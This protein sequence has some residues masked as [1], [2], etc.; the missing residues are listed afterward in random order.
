LIALGGL[1]LAMGC[2]STPGMPV[3]TT[4][5][6][7][8][9]GVPCPAP[10]PTGPDLSINPSLK[11]P[12]LVAGP[13][14]PIILPPGAQLPKQ[15]ELVAPTLPTLPSPRMPDASAIVPPKDITP[16]LT[17]NP[18]PDVGTLPAPAIKPLLVEAPRP[19]AGPDGFA[20]APIIPPPTLQET[21]PPP[22][23]TNGQGTPPLPLR[24]GQRFGHAPDYKWIAGVLDRHTKGGYWT[25]RYADFG[26]DDE[27]GGKVRLLDDARLN[28]FSNGDV[29]FI[30]GDLLAPRSAAL[31]DGSSFPPFRINGVRLIEKAK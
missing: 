15:G 17:S 6:L 18:K 23:I 9:A 20:P 1:M 28:E 2:K 10:T 26:N 4:P 22:K 14:K 29:V 21:L 30:E 16:T 5:L 11:P 12:T 13:G 19:P 8:E 3:V 24:A 31:I 7:P 27:W 25:L